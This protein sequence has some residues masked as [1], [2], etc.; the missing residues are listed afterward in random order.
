[1]V[2]GPLW[3]RMELSSR[4]KGLRCP[5]GDLHPYWLCSFR[6]LHCVPA[7]DALPPEYSPRVNRI[8]GGTLGS[9]ESLQRACVPCLRFSCLPQSTPIYSSVIINGRDA[10]IQTRN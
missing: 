8:I 1:M 2:I 3:L 10:I 5:G 4:M 7:T 6:E 9:H